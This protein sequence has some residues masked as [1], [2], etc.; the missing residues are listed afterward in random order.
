MRRIKNRKTPG[1]RDL[2][3]GYTKMEHF[4]ANNASFDF[5]ISVKNKQHLQGPVSYDT[6]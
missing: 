1:V 3:S 4:A 2:S 6:P 5:N